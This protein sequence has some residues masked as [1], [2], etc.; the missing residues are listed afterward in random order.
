[1]TDAAV[2][3][4][5]LRE[6]RTTLGLTQQN[7]ADTIGIPRSAVAE[8]ERGRRAVSGLELRHLA[9]LYRRSIGWL[10]GDADTFTLDPEL[11]AAMTALTAHDR[12]LVIQFARFLDQRNHS[13]STGASA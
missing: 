2:L 13:T 6:A 3:A 4:S 12:D 11:S 5:R 1:M 9:R 10:C 8:I 7:A